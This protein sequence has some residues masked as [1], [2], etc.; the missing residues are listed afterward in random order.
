MTEISKE[1]PWPPLIVA[2]SVPLLVRWRDI[3]LTVLAWGLIGFLL[4]KEVTGEL[5]A[6]DALAAGAT[7]SELGRLDFLERLVPFLL[8][9]LVL[10]VVLIGFSVQ[11]MRR[12]S[13]ALLLP[14]PT[15]LAASDEARR[16]GLDEE[17]LLAGREDRIVI[18]HNADTRIRI[19]RRE[20]YT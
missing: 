10:P 2:Q 3:I 12:R 5:Q 9:A 19:E 16:T 13:R 15:P 4:V 1:R 8:L 11:T 14:Q 17:A 6:L 20:G 18:V 7:G